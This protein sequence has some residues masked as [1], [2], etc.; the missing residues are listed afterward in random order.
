MSV[1]IF[2]LIGIQGKLDETILKYYF[3]FSQDIEYMTGIYPGMY[4]QL[5]WR[6]IGPIM[7]TG[8]LI[9]SVIDK[10]RNNPEY[11]AWSAEKVSRL[12]TG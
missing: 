8:L 11:A 12:R 9:G 7:L 3:R 4:W 1:G 2:E 5:T 10:V 6:F